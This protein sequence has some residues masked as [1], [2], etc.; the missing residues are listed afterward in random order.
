MTEQHTTWNQLNEASRGPTPEEIKAF[1]V[2]T[3][4]RKAVEQQAMGDA[5]ITF[6]TPEGQR[7]L[8]WLEDQ[9]VNQTTLPTAIFQGL[10]G[11]SVAILQNIREGEN[12]LVRRIRSIIKKGTQ[13]HV[14]A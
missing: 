8:T 5:I 7:F 6:S 13:S 3:E 4:R 10:D 12:N 2:E 11:I 1:E 9:T 14:A